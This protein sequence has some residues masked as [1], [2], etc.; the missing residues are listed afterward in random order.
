MDTHELSNGQI[1]AIVKAEGAELCS[2]RDSHGREFLWQAEPAWPRH[3]PILF[4]IVGRLKNDTLLHRGKSYPMKQHGFARDMRFEWGERHPERCTLSLE[5]S[6][7]TRLHYPFSFRLEV[8]YSLDGEQLVIVYRITNPADES[9]PAS[10]GA[11]P[12]FAWPLAAGIAKDAHTITFSEPESALVRRLAGGLLRPELSSSP[13][14]GTELALSESLFVDD[15]MILDRLATTSLRYAAPGG[16]AIALSWEGFSEL[17]I[18]SKPGAPF[19]CIEPWSGFASPIDFD[20]EF[21]TKPGI[22][23]LAPGGSR[24]LT[25]RI[26]LVPSALSS[27]D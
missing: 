10:I 11:H 7:A 24:S 17:G 6:A 3:A 9:L 5:D 21:E 20:G 12:A 14:R 2:L 16:P 15:A 22:V 1:T 26:G 23:N 13:I 19:L 8:T 18:W 25:Q 4:P 27:Q